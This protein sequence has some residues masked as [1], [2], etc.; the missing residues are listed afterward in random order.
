MGAKSWL[1]IDHCPRPRSY[2]TPVGCELY[3]PEPPGGFQFGATSRTASGCPLLAGW[4]TYVTWLLVFAAEA[5][6]T[7]LEAPG[8]LTFRLKDDRKG[9]AAMCRCDNSSRPQSHENRATRDAKRETNLA[10]PIRNLTSE[11]GEND[12]GARALDSYQ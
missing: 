6:C 11:V 8:L 1:K 5:I 3:T 12:V 4:S 10:E 9:I 2:Q 7:T